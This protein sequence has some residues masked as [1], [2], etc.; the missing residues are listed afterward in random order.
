MPNQLFYPKTTFNYRVGSD[1]NS[2]YLP[3][4]RNQMTQDIT[5]A[6]GTLPLGT[7]IVSSLKLSEMRE[8]V[9]VGM[10]LFNT[11]YGTPGDGVGCFITDVDYNTDTITVT[12]NPGGLNVGG[13]FRIFK[14]APDACLIRQPVVDSSDILELMDA[15]GNILA[16][17]AGPSTGATLP[18]PVSSL[19]AAC[20]FQV[21]QIRKNSQIKVSP[22]DY[23]ICMWN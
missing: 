8:S 17:P 7:T 11:S 4:P 22:F 6:I 5:A 3:S 10:A 18:G 19:A 13:T 16:W 21:T 9:K 20:P 2:L 15:E 14:N 23:V 12:A 1:S